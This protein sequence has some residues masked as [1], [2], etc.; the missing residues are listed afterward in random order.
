[1]TEKHPSQDHRALVFLETSGNQAYLFGTNK[2]KENIGASQLTYL[3]GAEWAPQA[4][5][6]VGGFCVLATSGKAIFCVPGREEGAELVR[7]VTL[8]A[9]RE[10]PGLSVA[11]A[12]VDLTQGESK[13]LEE[14]HLRFNANRDA[15]GA[16]RFPCLPWAER[17]ATSGYSAS[18]S[19]AEGKRPLW[20]GAESLA[21]REQA[22]G[23]IT[24]INKMLKEQAK[25][26]TRLWV[27]DKV[28]DL[29]K[30][31]EA[32]Q[33]L[34]V[35][36]SDGNGLGQIFMD[37]DRHLKTLKDQARE[38]ETWTH[39]ETMQRISQ[40]LEGATQRAF[41]AACLHIHALEASKTQNGKTYIPVIPLVLAGDDMTVMVEG[42]YALPFA[43]R[44][45]TAFEEET[46]GADCPTIRRIAEVALG[47]PRLSAGA[48]VAL[49]K[50]HFPFHLAH[51]LAEALLK[52]AKLAKKALKQNLTDSHGA[53]E[54]PYPVSA[55]DFHVLFDASFTDLETIRK[56]RLTVRVSETESHRLY[57]GPYVVTP[58]N[59]LQGAPASGIAWA[60]DHHFD[61]LIDRFEALNAEDRE[62]NRLCLPSS[63]MHAL[64]EAVAHGKESADARQRE[65][66]WLQD[67][68]LDRLDEGGSSLFFSRQSDGKSHWVTR[69]VDAINGAGFWPPPE[70]TDQSSQEA[71]GADHD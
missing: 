32:S 64:R 1:M 63:Q 13:A 7:R 49:V 9:L 57:G 41:Y 50:H 38:G 20:L 45:L 61:K 3:A 69:F 14:A 30:D 31:F 19:G 23:W 54:A 5:S 44:F 12:V 25:D 42:T 28:D 67:K 34:G 4:A 24:R 68:G 70:S 37:L 8:R 53:R 17:C 26:G 40:E 39:L 29:Q 58:E 62:S 22:G 16:P 21:K 2:L 10:A 6:A 47:A 56:E 27:K 52:S 18:G 65:L 46:G 33:W 71:E 55:L 15:L 11:G 51:A 48:G 60:Q 36:F 66:H 59:R 43:Q 35:I